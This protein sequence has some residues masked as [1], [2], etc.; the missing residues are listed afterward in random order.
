MN[1]KGVTK[2]TWIRTAVTVLA[3]INQML[4]MFGKEVFPYTVDEMYEVCSAV[5]T[6]V[7]TVISWWNNN[8]FTEV[9]QLAD[10]AG[11]ELKKDLQLE[12]DIIENRR[13]RRRRY[14]YRIN[15]QK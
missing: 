14:K 7:M 10:K 13:K 9:A 15:T 5:A 2:E 3:L 1:F 4:V 8:S 11:V 6:V 12:S